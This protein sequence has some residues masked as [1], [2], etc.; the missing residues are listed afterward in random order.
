MAHSPTTYPAAAPSAPAQRMDDEGAF[1]PVPPARTSVVAS[2]A[3]FTTEQCL[4]CGAVLSG[5]FCATCGQ[6]KAA[7]IGAKTVRTETWER[8]RWFEWGPIKKALRVIPKPGTV[9]REYV[10]GMRKDHMHPMSLLLLAIGFLLIVLGYTDYLKPGF[11]SE[12]AAKM[13]ELVKNYSKWSF[14]LGIVAVFISTVTVFRKRLGYNLTEILAFSIY[15]QAVFIGLQL[16][17]QLP[18][19]LVKTPEMLKWHKTWSPWYMTGLQALML[20][21][22]QKQF[23]LVNL[24]QDGWRLLVAGA[25]FAV[26]KWEATKLYAKGVVELVVWQMGL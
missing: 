14:S 26:L 6:K 13:Y 17:N 23:F 21:V 2:D 18:V 12:V 1:N 15:C 24:R 3:L 10:L 25:L 4:N 9:A 20:M 11:P 22:A 16:A 5:A 7:R 19:A 8:F